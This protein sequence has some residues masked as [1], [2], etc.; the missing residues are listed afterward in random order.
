M[1]NKNNFLSNK[2]ATEYLHCLSNIFTKY[3]N[4]NVISTDVGM[5][6]VSIG[7]FMQGKVAL[8]IESLILGFLFSPYGIPMVGQQ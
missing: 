7:S 6:V 4:S 8:E 5:C 2:F 3:R 1:D